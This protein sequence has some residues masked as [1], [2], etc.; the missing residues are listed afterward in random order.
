MKGANQ[1]IT[2]YWYVFISEPGLV[3]CPGRRGYVPCIISYPYVPQEIIKSP[4]HTIYAS[5]TCKRGPLPLRLIPLYSVHIL[6][7]DKD[8]DYSATMDNIIMKVG[9][10]RRRWW[11]IHVPCGKCLDGRRDKHN[12]SV[13]P[14][15]LPVCLFGC[16]WDYVR[17]NFTG[18]Y[19]TCGEAMTSAVR[20]C[21]VAASFLYDCFGVRLSFD[22]HLCCWLWFLLIIA[23]WVDDW[24]SSYGA[25]LVSGGAFL[26]RCQVEKDDK[27][28]RADLASYP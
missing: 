6:K 7:A 2:S 14:A 1:H 16:L 17:S 12:T 9:Y 20:G 10:I 28:S 24:V 13:G 26:G 11:L 15:S 21:D 22:L 4:T 23:S 25:V 5:W 19:G 8:F 27:D 18:I 3:A